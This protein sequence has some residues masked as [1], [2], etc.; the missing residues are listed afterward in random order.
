MVTPE[1]VNTRTQPIALPDVVRYLVGVLE[2]VE[3]RGQVYEIGGPEV[4]RYI[5]MMQR[6]AAVH[7]QVPAATSACRCS[8]P[9]CP[10]AGSRWSPTSTSATA[11]N[12]VDSMT[13]EMVVRGPLDRGRRPRPDDRVRRG[14][15]ARPGRPRARRQRAR[16]VTGSRAGGEVRRADLIDKVPRDH[17]QPD[18]EFRRRRVVVAVLLVVGRRCSA[19]RCR[20]ARR[21][22]VLP[23]DPRG[24]GGLGARRGAVRPA[25][26]GLHRAAG[27]AGPAGAR[28]GRARAG[29]RRGVHPGRAGRAR[30]RAAARLRRGPAG[31]RA[32]GLARA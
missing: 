29:L 16:W 25:A 28:L 11:R 23:A 8:R 1:W 3:A 18:E 10:R 2:P 15:A 6:A 14:R 20:C 4:L 19:S 24:G 17:Q 13:N 32:Q 12:L 7:G 27:V 21:R 26:P 22:D 30:D 31:P 5:D 9:G